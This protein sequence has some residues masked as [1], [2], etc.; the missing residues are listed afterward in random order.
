[1]VR[2][3]DRVNRVNPSVVRE[4]FKLMADPDIISFGGGSPAPESFEPAAIREITEELMT[5]HPEAMLQYGTTE[6]WTPVRDAYI[7]H[8]ARP[9]G[10]N[11]SRDNVIVT[12]GSSQG[13]S[14]SI[15]TFVND[16]DAVLVESPTFLATLM[17]LKKVNARVVAVEMDDEGMSTDDL[18]SKLESTGARFIYTIPT[19]QNPTGR[20]MSLARRKEVARLA[21]EYDAVVAEDDPYCDLRYAG[22]PLPSIKNFDTTGNVVLLNSFSKTISPGLRVGTVAAS[23]EIIG[24]IVVAKQCSDTH[25]AILPQAVCAEYLNRGLMPR[26][27]AVTA[28][29]YKE[30]L[31]TM[32]GCIDRYLPADTE[33]TRPDGGLFVWLTLAGDHDMQKLLEAATQKY[34][35]AFVPGEPFFVDASA[36]GVRNTFRLNFSGESPARIE[37]GMRRLGQAFQVA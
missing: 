16:G 5:L 3:A 20:T 28:P 7:E 29:M 22:E 17:M 6:G 32:L 36:S 13:I 11:F 31:E 1:M 10:L 33:Y 26:H 37:E 2:F 27:L 4:I 35:V 12:T 24:K 30:R 18:R 14:L 21:S 23:T 34:K 25:T 19:F 15:D 9:K 8:I